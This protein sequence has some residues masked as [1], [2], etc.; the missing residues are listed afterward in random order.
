MQH[1]IPFEDDV[2]VVFAGDFIGIGVVDVVQLSVF[3]S[4]NLHIFRKQRIQTQHTVLAVS[5]DLRI[6]VAV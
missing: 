1:L 2:L 6:G 4:I 3:G 5:D